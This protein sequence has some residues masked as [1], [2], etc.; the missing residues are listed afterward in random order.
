M[1]S[2][3]HYP[4]TTGLLEDGAALGEALVAGD[5]QEGR[6]RAR[7]IAG[8]ALSLNLVTVR[9]AAGAVI[10]YLGAGDQLPLPGY[11]AAVLALSGALLEIPG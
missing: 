11:A 2:T 9:A 8:A 3:D 6:F 1:P 7:L 10:H 4:A 5:L